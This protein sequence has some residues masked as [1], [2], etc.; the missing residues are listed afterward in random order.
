MP[1]HERIIALTEN[2]LTRSRNSIYIYITELRTVLL[3]RVRAQVEFE[4]ST[5]VC[6]CVGA[7]RGERVSD[8]VNL[9]RQNIANRP[10]S[11]FPGLL[12]MRGRAEQKMVEQK[13]CGTS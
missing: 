10:L 12:L 6:M 3:V 2:D 8:A 4:G 9:A 13:S 1:A 5:G 7:M 11:V